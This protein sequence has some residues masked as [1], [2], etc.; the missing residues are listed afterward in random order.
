MLRLSQADDG[1][2][3]VGP[4]IHHS[5]SVYLNAIDPNGPIGGFFRVGERPRQA[6]AEVTA[7]LYLPE[8]DVLFS[9]ARPATGPVPTFSAGGLRWEVLEPFERWH[10]VYEGTVLRLVEPGL[11]ADPGR[12]YR[13]CPRVRLAVDWEVQ[14]A[15]P[16][17]GGEPAEP[18]ERPG[19]E[20]ARGHY[21]QLVVVSGTLSVDGRP[22]A[23]GGAGLRDHSWGPRHWHAPWYYRWCTACSG[24]DFGFAATWLAR[25]DGGTLRTGFVWDDGQLLP[26]GGLEL[27]TSWR[28]PELWQEAISLRFATPARRYQVAGRVLRCLPLRH[29]RA[30]QTGA[31]AD[32]DRGLTRITEG[33]TRYELD[34]GRVAYGIAEYLDQLE[35]GRPVGLSV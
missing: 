25:R 32:P 15:A 17:V 33:L 14:A 12:A 24:P 35:A 7:C 2:H 16:A 8:G 27:A 9:F 20:F 23:F 11:L 21:E 18:Q 13:E 5:E 31:G 6:Q 1:P 34:D 29:R 28:E 22:Q 4:E 30:E 26:L 10:L 3:A 19:E